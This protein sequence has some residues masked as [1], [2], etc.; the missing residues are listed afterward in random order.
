MDIVIVGDK[1]CN[2]SDKF[3]YVSKK[4][5]TASEDVHFRYSGELH[6]FFAEKQILL[7]AGRDCPPPPGKKCKGPCLYNVIVARCPVFCPVT[8]I[9]HWT[10]KAM[11]ERVFASAYHPCQVP[12]GTS[13]DE[14]FQQMANAEGGKGCTEN[15]PEE[16]GPGPEFNEPGHEMLSAGATA[17]V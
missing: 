5:I 8:G 16:E 4:F 13:C 9:L 14:Y 3:T 6:I 11:S 7:M 12:C 1:E 17:N 15:A 10:E 2:P